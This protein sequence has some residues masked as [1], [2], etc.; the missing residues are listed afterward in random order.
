MNSPKTITDEAQQ[1]TKSYSAV[2]VNYSAEIDICKGVAI[3]AVLWHHSLILYPVNLLNV[4]WCQYVWIIDQTFFMQIF[5]FISGYLFATSRPKSYKTILLNKVKRLLI[6]YFSYELLNLLLKLLAPSLVNRKVDTVSGYLHQ[7]F[8]WGGELWFVYVLFFMFVVWAICLKKT[9][10]KTQLAIACIIIVCCNFISTDQF[11]TFFLIGEVIRYSPIFIIGYVVKSVNTRIMLSNL[12]IVATTILFPTLCL[13]FIDRFRGNASLWFLM[14][15]AGCWF[16][17]TMSYLIRKSEI[18]T[19]VLGFFGKNSLP[20]YWLNGFALVL[21][22]TAAV[23]ICPNDNTVLLFFCV[24]VLCVG[25]EILMLIAAQRTP[26]VS[27][28]I[29]CN[30]LGKESMRKREI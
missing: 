12:N 5:F 3:L 2:A 22:R 6:P 18:A 26:F 21:A 11:N 20:L 30:S 4:R 8:F 28:L 16:V 29:G 17:W 25:I 9:S 15:F 1:N 27:A 24:F 7:M 23:K 13:L 19:K 10:N 14:S